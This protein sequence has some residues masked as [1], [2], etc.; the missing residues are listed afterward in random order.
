[1]SHTED[2]ERFFA[3]IAPEA[4]VALLGTYGCLLIRHHDGTWST[5][6][7]QADYSDQARYKAEIEPL[8]D[9]DGA[10]T[11]MEAGAIVRVTAEDLR[12]EYTHRDGEVSRWTYKKFM[13]SM[14]EIGTVYRM[15]DEATVIWRERI[16]EAEEAETD[17]HEKAEALKLA[18]RMTREG[19][20]AVS[21][22]DGGEYCWFDLRQAARE[23]GALT[24]KRKLPKSD[25]DVEPC[26]RAER[27]GLLGI[28]DLGE[29][30]VY[31]PTEEAFSL[32][33][34]PLTPES[35]VAPPDHRL[36]YTRKRR[37]KGVAVAEQ[38]EVRI[39]RPWSPRYRVY[40]K[41]DHLIGYAI[42]DISIEGGCASNTIA[43][44]R[45]G[46]GVKFWHL[47]SC[48][49]D[50]FQENIYQEL[51]DL[52]A[53]LIKAGRFVTDYRKVVGHLD[54]EAEVIKALEGG[55]VIEGRSDHILMEPRVDKVHGDL[56]TVKWGI[57]G[58][59][60]ADGVIV[61]IESFKTHYIRKPVYAHVASELG[62][63][64]RIVAK[65]RKPKRDR[66]KVLA[67]DDSGVPITRNDIKRESNLPLPEGMPINLLPPFDF[68]GTEDEWDVLQTI[69]A[70]K[71]RRK[72]KAKATDKE[73]GEFT[74]DDFNWN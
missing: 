24:L 20:A 25:F 29:E 53:D 10:R 54:D 49:L 32:F 51:D 71:Y 14:S 15:T 55:E 27:E 67:Y 37:L 59:L 11:L 52:V 34:I 57:V 7:Y 8:A 19:L 38:E 43:G 41:L 58:K 21:R 22:Y 23:D 45:Q 56:R 18:E 68:K 6:D 46:E 28:V 33:E 72:H 50:P 9:A 30:E 63:R 42:G 16:E 13:K 40:D 47:H 48:A 31:F 4:A 17:A 1:M 66:S 35:P 5:T 36:Q 73:D 39:N 26:Y 65:P 60:L 64:L 44:W 2:R 61:E 3:S 69:E 12:H 62:Q 70:V 74:F